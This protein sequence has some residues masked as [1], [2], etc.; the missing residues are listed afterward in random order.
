MDVRI[1]HLNLSV[2]DFAE[3]VAWYGRV[4]DFAL[5]EEGTYEGAPFGVLRSNRGAGDALLCTYHRPDY[6]FVDNE[7]QKRRGHHGIRHSGFRI[8]DEARWRETIARERLQVEERAYPHSHSWY[9]VDPTGYEI[10]VVHW[11]EDRIAFGR[12]IQ[13]EAR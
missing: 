12:A 13:K 9:V 3:S 8:R 5:V 10:E 2:R 6:A 4:F 11:N 7:D 1:D